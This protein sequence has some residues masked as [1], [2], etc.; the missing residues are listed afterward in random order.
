MVYHLTPF[1]KSY[2]LQSFYGKESLRRIAYNFRENFHLPISAAT[3]LRRAVENTQIAYEG[4]EYL[5]KKEPLLPSQTESDFSPR[6][7]D[8]WEIDEIWL[9]LGKKNFPF[10]VVKDLKTCFFPAANLEKK[11]TVET[12]ANVLISARELARKCP[13]ELRG[14]GNPAYQEAVK[15]VFGRKTTLIINKKTSKAGENKS[16]EATFGGSIRS[17]IKSKRSLHSWLISPIVL[18][19][20]IL[21]YHFARPCEALCGQTPAKVTM[22]WNPLDGIRGWPALLQLGEYYAKKTVTFRK[23]N[24]SY[25]IQKQVTLDG[26]SLVNSSWTRTDHKS[27]SVSNKQMR[28]GSFLS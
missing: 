11:S 22:D 24:H 5:M 16:I 18:K 3:V 19:G 13:V 23:Q 9:P 26:L 6:F 7:G 1:H 8:I 20:Y 21:D 2:I 4:V 27:T 14:D 15:R 25:R 28:L 10:I 12:T 17:W